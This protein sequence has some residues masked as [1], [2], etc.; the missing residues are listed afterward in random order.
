VVHLIVVHLTV[1]HLT[2]V[3]LMLGVVIRYLLIV[4]SEYR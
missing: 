1:I 3:H 2:V 4:V